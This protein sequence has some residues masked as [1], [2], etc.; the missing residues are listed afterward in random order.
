MKWLAVAMAMVAAG[1]AQ[2][3]PA[4]DALAIAR[5]MIAFK[6]VAGA[7]NQSPQLGAYLRDELVKG[8]FAPAEVTVTPLADTAYLVATWSGSDR[9]AKPIVISGHM[10][11]VAANPADWQRD[12]F[13]PVVENG[14]LY[15]RGSTDMKLSAAIVIAALID[16]KRSG[17]RPTRDIVFTL[18]G[19][20]ETE[21]RTGQAL[22]QRY[23]KAEMVLNID[24][25]GGVFSEA[26][27]PLY[28]T[29]EGAEKTYADFRLTVTNPGGHSSAPRDDNAIVQLSAALTRIGAYRF[30]PELNEITR[31]YFTK[32]AAFED[33][34][35]G[36]AMRAFATDPTD[37][38]AIA[39]LR[40]DPSMVGKIGTTCV[41][42]LL[43]GGHAE[44]A[45]PQ[46][47]TANIN[48][49]IFPGHK[50]AAIMAELKRVAADPAITFE[51]VTQGATATDASPLTPRLTGA[52]T[53]ALAKAYPGVP[54]VPS[55][56]SGASD[57]MWFRA[58]GVP[59]YGVSP[60]F[61]KASDEFS[62]GLN[63]RTEVRTIAPSIV[64][65]RAL[66]TTL[67]K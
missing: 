20:E 8:G 53:A 28:M 12:P 45:L 34:K 61:I 62:H 23:R 41:P 38:R 14:Y 32:A 39:T 51:D 58:V 60:I 40:A 59:S 5:R 47:A 21:M 29:L 2:A 11:V 50:P 10:D 65:Y 33:A 27:K 63:E 30:T 66:L 18:S 31:G 36:A 67:A 42:T 55:Q 64:Y 19:D 49:R 56:S 46:R 22:A 48:C 15:G 13:T 4:D 9:R 35:T 3:T 37:A 57:S 16:L 17:F 7:G 43:S 6:S 24:G 44:N 52:V 26:G 25:A 1:A 54:L